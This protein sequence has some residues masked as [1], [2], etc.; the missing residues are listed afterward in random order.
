MKLLRNKKKKGFTLVELMVVVAILG[1]LIAIAAPDNS[2]S[3]KKAEL[4]ATVDFV[5]K[6]YQDAVEECWA[7]HGKMDQCTASNPRSGITSINHKSQVKGAKISKVFTNINGSNKSYKVTVYTDIKYGTKNSEKFAYNMIAT[8]NSRNF[9]N[10][11]FNDDKH[12]G[13]ACS[14]IKCS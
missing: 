4:I 11:S 8:V 10:W 14:Y 6:R 1:I 13:G 9:I 12:A 2:D 7:Y 3:V 5:T